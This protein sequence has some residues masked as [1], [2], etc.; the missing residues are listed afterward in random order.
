MATSNIFKNDY[1]DILFSQTQKEYRDGCEWTEHPIQ[2]NGSETTFG[3][4]EAWPQNFPLEVGTKTEKSKPIHKI[5]AVTKD[6]KTTFSRR[7]TD[8]YMSTFSRSK[9][10]EKTYSN[11]TD[12]TDRQKTANSNAMDT[13][14]RKKTANS[15][16][17]DTTYKTKTTKSNDTFAKSNPRN[18]QDNKTKKSKQ[19]QT[20]KQKKE[21]EFSVRG[22]NEDGQSPVGGLHI[23]GKQ[24][25]Y[26]DKNKSQSSPVEPLDMKKEMKSEAKDLSQTVISSVVSTFICSVIDKSLEQGFKN[27][28]FSESLKSSLMSSLQTLKKGCIT[29]S[30]RVFFKWLPTAVTQLKCV[31]FRRPLE[32]I[33]DTLELHELI[34]KFRDDSLTDWEAAKQI[35]IKAV[36]IVLRLYIT[37]QFGTGG[38]IVDMFVSVALNVIEHLVNSYIKSYQK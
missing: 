1:S 33:D 35:F 14:Y 6:V 30:I 11:R 29:S 16:D 25:D 38:Y 13:T 15:N 2:K 37:F 10:G 8:K 27:I 19:R 17:T 31:N 9:E 18:K 22:N 36:F 7:D 24:T 26:T 4:E 21:D 5:E 12:A 23:K 3:F 20:G 28:D 32:F 34:E